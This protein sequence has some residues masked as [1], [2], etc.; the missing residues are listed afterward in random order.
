MKKRRLPIIA[1]SLMSLLFLGSCA[2]TLP[3]ENEQNYAHYYLV[4]FYVDNDLY[5]T[6]RVKEGETIG[7]IIEAPTKDDYN[8]R[9]LKHQLKTTITLLAGKLVMELPLI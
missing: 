8:F 2:E 9:L 1:T 3:P 4:S 5:R 7:E 6:A